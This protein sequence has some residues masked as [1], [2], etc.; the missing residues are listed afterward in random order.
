MERADDLNV[1]RGGLFQHGLDGH[2]E[3]PHN[4]KVVSCGLVVPGL[5]RIQ[6]TKFS[7]S[8][9]AE[10][11]FIKT[12]IGE[13][14][15]GP[16]NHGSHH[17]GKLVFPQ[18]KGIAFLYRESITEIQVKIKRQHLKGFGVADHCGGGV[19]FKESLHTGS[20]VRLHMGNHQIIRAFAAKSLFQI[21]QIRIL[22]SSVNRVHYRNFI[23]ENHIRIISDAV[24]N[25]KLPFKEV[26]ILIVNTHIK[27]IV[28]HH[29]KTP[30]VIISPG[31]FQNANKI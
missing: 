31:P 17:K 16:V 3:F 19:F 8:V 23:I 14:D 7:E 12:V 20:V 4:I 28:C 25:R 29:Y 22:F 27:N 15:L 30:P 18:R 26:N 5:L 10:Q 13:H 9:G 2:S 6:R 24:R 21:F 1:Q 11:N